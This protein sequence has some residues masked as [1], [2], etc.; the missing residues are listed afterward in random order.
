MSDKELRQQAIDLK[1]NAWLQRFRNGNGHEMSNF[2]A[3]QIASFIDAFL[4]SVLADLDCREAEE[5]ERALPVTEEW[6]ESIGGV[7]EEGPFAFGFR[8][9]RLTLWL[10]VNGQ[11]WMTEDSTYGGRCCLYKTVCTRGQ[12]LDLL[13]ALGVKPCQS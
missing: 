2:A 3:M 13:L 5:A 6:L 4:D 1:N 9:M 10:R 12:V 7:W 11:A 8:Y